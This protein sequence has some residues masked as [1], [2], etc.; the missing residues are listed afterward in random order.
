MKEANGGDQD[1]SDIEMPKKVGR[2]K[3]RENG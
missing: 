3:E 1:M 2:C